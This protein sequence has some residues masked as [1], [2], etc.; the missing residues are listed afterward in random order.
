MSMKMASMSTLATVLAAALALDE[1]VDEVNPRSPDKPLEI[2]FR[3]FSCAECVEEKRLP[4]DSAPS[5]EIRI[6]RQPASTV[7][8]SIGLDFEK[9]VFV[10]AS[11]NFTIFSALEKT[12]VKPADSRFLAADLGRLKEIFPALAIDAPTVVL[13][14]HQRAHLYQIRAERV[15]A[16]F[17]ALTAC[18]KKH[19]G[20]GAPYEV[21][22]FEDYATHHK[23]VDVYMGI[24]QDKMGVTHH[25][26]EKPNFLA[27][28][29]YEAITPEG[30]WAFAN[31][32][33]H[34]IAHNL[35][36]GYNNYSKE[37][38]AWFEEGLAH[39]YERRET[40]NHNTFCW[41]EGRAPTMFEKPS[42]HS[43]ILNMVRREKDRNLAEWCE[44]SQPGELS[45]EEQGLSW[46]IVKWL[47]ETEPV[48]V[49]R[50]LDKLEEDYLKTVS[51]SECVEHGFGVSPSVLHERWRE[52][53]LKDYPKK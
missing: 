3:P 5:E 39:Y 29:A 28:S 43:T 27:I 49:T 44:K 19:V 17:A 16:H 41:T 4:A 52:H 32:V 26:R 1:P 2:V 12:K 40:P 30:D 8:K 13:S 50:M 42:W 45:A 15:F 47:V 24:S 51:A 25:V 37:T 22:L 21:Y 10:V 14:A 46:S 53:V 38:W 36:D 18:A 31:L 11:P 48:R 34:S 20:T 7:A 6:L 23:L 9:E 35:V 33:I